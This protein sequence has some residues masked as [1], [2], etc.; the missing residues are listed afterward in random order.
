[1]APT[2]N[3][4]DMTPPARGSVVGGD[5]AGYS[6]SNERPDH[7]LEAVSGV[8]PEIFLLTELHSRKTMLDEFRRIRPALRISRPKLYAVTKPEFI[9]GNL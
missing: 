2:P 1:M 6:E 7:F 5:R 9:V 3:L 4:L 8:G